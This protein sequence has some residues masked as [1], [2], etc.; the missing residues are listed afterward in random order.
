MDSGLGKFLFHYGLF[1]TALL[2][3]TAISA[4]KNWIGLR[5]SWW[6]SVLA[7]LLAAASYF[8]AVLA[9]EVA[10]LLFAT[11]RIGEAVPAMLVGFWVGVC[12]GASVLALALYLV[13]KR[14]DQK[15]FKL[16]LLVG[17]A[18]VT[19]AFVI[20]KV[21]KI[22]GPIFM[23]LKATVFSLLEILVQ[24]TLAVLCGYWLAP[25][26]APATAICNLQAEPPGLP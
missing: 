13:T 17:M 3:A 4:T 18:S 6:R 12:A 9:A 21:W 23:A 16:L 24:P 11:V 26:L 5:P 10:T 14:W 7:W 8:I 22:D 1:A 15:A 20:L 25:D 2:A 19:V